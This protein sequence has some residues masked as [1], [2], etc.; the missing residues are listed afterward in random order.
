VGQGDRGQGRPDLIGHVGL[1][2]EP[3]DADIG[4]TLQAE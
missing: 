4:R 1:V 3:D 2:V